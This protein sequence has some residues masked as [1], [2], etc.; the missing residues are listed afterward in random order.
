MIDLEKKK[1]KKE[2]VDMSKT[3]I[4]T[5]GDTWD[6][7][8]FKTLGKESFNNVLIQNN[9][10]Y[11]DTV[12]F[13]AGISINIPDVEEKQNQSSLPPWKQSR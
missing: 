7:I 3:Y 10:A 8:A 12:L 13:S 6:Y 2:E 4:T 1:I 5:L 9:L 11:I